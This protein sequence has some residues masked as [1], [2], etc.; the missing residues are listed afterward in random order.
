MMTVEIKHPEKA[1][2]LF[3][4]TLEVQAYDLGPLCLLFG[5]DCSLG[6]PLSWLWQAE[7]ERWRHGE[8]GHQVASSRRSCSL[9]KLR[10]LNFCALEPA[11]LRPA[12]PAL[13]FPVGLRV[14]KSPR[15]R[16]RRAQTGGAAALV[17]CQQGHF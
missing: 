9:G 13:G 15:G 16:Q 5:G 6:A 8:G 11:W 3:N 12:K 14:Q 10:P 1:G 17:P 2:C 4:P 7:G